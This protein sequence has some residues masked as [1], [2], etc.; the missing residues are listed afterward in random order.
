MKN[1][2]GLVYYIILVFILSVF[3][4]AIGIIEFSV[5]EYSGYV[6]VFY[7]VIV[8]INHF[9]KFNR[10]ALFAGMT[11][12]L[13]GILLLTA[14]YFEFTNY[15]ILVVPAVLFIC[16]AGFFILFIEDTKYF[17]SIVLSVVF[18]AA[19]IAVIYTSGKLELNLF[20]LSAWRVLKEY[21]AV[22]IITI[23]IILLQWRRTTD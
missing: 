14:S 6:L 4:K 11:I 13:T 16:S 18:L 9:G 3:L 22:F 2:P 15:R 1:N 8:V 10:T 12:F 19:G 17:L 5:T 20:L 7:G 21:W 23:V